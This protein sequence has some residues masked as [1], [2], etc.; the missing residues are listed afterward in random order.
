[1]RPN[2]YT[3]GLILKRMLRSMGFLV[4]LYPREATPDT[5]GTGPVGYFKCIVVRAHWQFVTLISCSV[6]NSMVPVPPPSVCGNRWG[7]CWGLGCST[8][9]IGM[10]MKVM[11]PSGVEWSLYVIQAKI[12]TVYMVHYL[13]SRGLRGALDH[14]CYW[15]EFNIFIFDF[16]FISN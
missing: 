9:L 12:G 16:N 5:L 14:K 15:F 2:N 8:I 7:R 10:E 4:V 11:I 13:N 6:F 3:L 1:M